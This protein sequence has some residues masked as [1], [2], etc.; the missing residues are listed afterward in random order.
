[1]QGQE[2]YFLREI[3]LSAD[4]ISS[5]LQL[6]N[7]RSEILATSGTS[8]PLRFRRMNK[9]RSMVTFSPSITCLV[10][11]VTSLN[12]SHLVYDM[13]IDL[14]KCSISWL[15]NEIAC[16]VCNLLFSWYSSIDDYKTILAF[17]W[18]SAMQKWRIV[19]DKVGWNCSRC[20][21]KRIWF[22]NC[23]E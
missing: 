9:R 11:K 23:L 14:T 17:S 2:K 12:I 22:G 3:W 15:S 16:T 1:M 21:F 13:L 5:L 4:L 8:W 10:E 7:T 19:V 6:L 18:D 20:N